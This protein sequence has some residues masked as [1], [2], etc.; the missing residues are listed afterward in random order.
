MKTLE[1]RLNAKEHEKFCKAMHKKLNKRKM[2]VKDLAEVIGVSPRSIYNFENDST[3]NPSK[4]LASKIANELGIE[5]KDY[6]VKG[7]F[8][9]ILIPLAITALIVPFKV[10]ADEPKA[11]IQSVAEPVDVYTEVY[12]VDSGTD[13]VPAYYPPLYDTDLPLTLDEQKAIREICERKDLSYEFVLAIIETESG[14]KK[15]AHNPDGYFGLM[16]LGKWLK[17]PDPYDP[18]MNVEYG[19]DYL[20]KLFEEY[21]D[22]AYVL[23]VYNGNPNAQ[24]NFEKGIVSRYANKVLKR[25]EELERFYGK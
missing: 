22:D 6:K 15:K 13:F 14:Y 20:V 3:R 8:L 5:A 4:F 23:D 7:S 1:I 12:G 9:N 2:N 19:T 11:E 25:A 24:S 21:Q 17:C 16:Q 18:V 10:K